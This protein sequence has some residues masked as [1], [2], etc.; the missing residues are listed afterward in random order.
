MTRNPADYEKDYYAWTVEQARLLRSRELSAIDVANIAEEIESM[1]RSDR[2]EIGSRLTVLLLHLL[3]WRAQPRMRSSSWSGTVREQRRQIQKL[4]NE[5]PSLIPFVS[6]VLPESYADAREDAI[7][8]SNLLEAEFPKHCPFTPE[9]VL[10][11][12][13]LPDAPPVLRRSTGRAG[14]GLRAGGAAR[15]ERS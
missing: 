6:E 7:E 8:E 4:L 3:K 2:R 5:S 10:D 14:R 9:Q 12:G 15:P 11:R 1:G 13:F